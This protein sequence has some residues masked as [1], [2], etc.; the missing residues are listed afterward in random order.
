LV[1]S[2][3]A[4]RRARP[5]PR[6]S[7]PDAAT[8]SW[9]ARVVTAR[10]PTSRRLDGVQQR[11]EPEVHVQLLMTVK[12]GQAGLVGGE[13]DVDRLITADHGNVFAHSGGGSPGDVRDFERVA[14]QVDGVD[15]VCAV[16]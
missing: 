12:Q 10:G 14:V 6:V 1:P 3:K 16:A 4:I 11:H 7:R 2:V 13:V 5:H 15:V 9:C 8:P